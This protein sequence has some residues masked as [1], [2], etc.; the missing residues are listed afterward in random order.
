MREDRVAVRIIIAP[1]QGICANEVTS[2]NADG[3]VL[4][5]DVEVALPIVTRFQRDPEGLSAAT[6]YVIPV[7][8]LEHD[9]CPARL[10]LGYDELQARIALAH[11]RLHEV[12]DGKHDASE[13]HSAPGL[14]ERQPII[15]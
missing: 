10:E 12:G 2:A 6:T 11:A 14:P 1:Q 7:E 13:C 8:P 3:I 4:E 5:R 15:C 9:R